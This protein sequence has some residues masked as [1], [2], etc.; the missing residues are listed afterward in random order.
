MRKKRM[1]KTKL[2]V[3]IPAWQMRSLLTGTPP[4][5]DELENPFQGFAFWSTDACLLAWEQVKTSDYV[6]KWK[7]KNGLAYIEKQLRKDN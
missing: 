5:K 3:E 6:K 1:A 2:G 4:E 7:A